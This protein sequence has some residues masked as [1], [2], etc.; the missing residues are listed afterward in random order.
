[1]LRIGRKKANRRSKYF[2]LYAW[3]SSV[4]G[5]FVSMG[6]AAKNPRETFKQLIRRSKR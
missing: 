2:Y 4:T 3:R 5:K 1:M 6:F